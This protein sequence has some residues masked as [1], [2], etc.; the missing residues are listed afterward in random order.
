MKTRE[1]KSYMDLIN[2]FNKV[3]GAK[4][5]FYGNST[6][7][8][9]FRIDYSSKLKRQHQEILGNINQQNLKEKNRLTDQFGRQITGL[10]S[11]I[12]NLT[13]ENAQ[14]RTTNANLQSQFNALHKQNY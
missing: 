12:G 7:N 6:S 4:F 3:H 5:R 13:N 1:P 11:N 10:N 8:P 2:E 14:F 9:N